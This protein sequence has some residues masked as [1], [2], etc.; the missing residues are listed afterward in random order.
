MKIGEVKNQDNSIVPLRHPNKIGEVAK[1]KWYVLEAGDV[2]SFHTAL[3]SDQAP[4]VF[5]SD[6][7]TFAGVTAHELGIEYDLLR[8][9]TDS[10]V[11]TF[12]SLSSLRVREVLEV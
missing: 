5:A 9:A 3:R 10:E 11:D 12:L 8:N 6:K 4:L 7:D 2:V 1:I